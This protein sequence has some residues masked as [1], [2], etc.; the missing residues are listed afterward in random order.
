MRRLVVLLST[1]IASLLLT[2]GPAA[3]DIDGGEGW[4]GVNTDIMV[5]FFGFGVLIV[6]PALLTFLTLL[7]SRLDKRKYER[8]AAEKARAATRDERHGW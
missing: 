6:I 8:M 2:A 7:Q 4:W 3:A 1:A 5:T